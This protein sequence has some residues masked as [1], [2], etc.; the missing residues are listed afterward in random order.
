M[1]TSVR[2]AAF[3]ILAFVLA[4]PMPGSAQTE[5]LRPPEVVVHPSLATIDSMLSVTYPSNGPGA[6]VIV[7]HRGRTLLRKAYGLANIELGVA[8]RPEHVFRIASMTKQ[9]TAVAILIL[10]DEGRISLD[11]ELTRFFPEWPTQGHRITVEHLLAHTS[12]IRSYT[13]MLEFWTQM[14]RDMTLD[15]LISG[16]RDEPMDFAPGTDFRYNNSGYV[17]LGAIVEQISG[18]SY[19]AFLQDRIFEPLGMM[20]TR[21]EEGDAIVDRRV[22]GYSVRPDTP[23]RNAAY[24]S[25]SQPYAAGALLSTADDQLRWQRAVAAGAIL[26]PE[27]WDRTF[28]PT[29]LPDGRSTGYGF[30][31]FLG[32]AAGEPSIEHG[33]DINGFASEG[34]WIPSAELHVIVLSNAE[35]PFADPQ[36]VTLAVANR[37]LGSGETPPLVSVA[38]QTL[39]EYVGV[40]RISETE[41]RTVIR[42]GHALFSVRG[43]GSPQEMRPTGPDTFVYTSGGTRVT[44]LRGPSGQ[45]SAMMLEP[46]IGPAQIPSPRDP[47]ATPLTP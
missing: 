19:D 35:R 30:G 20:N 17:L 38:P 25:M 15:E 40:Y 32:T 39:D 14:R 43:P 22:S 45:V 5:P 34:M 1:G 6:T 36:D 47:E 41:R 3:F 29:T 24:L 7:S 16:F 21:L 31:W 44:F 26:R 27:S 12:G 37:L 2:L 46:R 28:T 18:M 11:D 8:T 13:S 9:F 10:V 4:A 23:L 42:E 33:G